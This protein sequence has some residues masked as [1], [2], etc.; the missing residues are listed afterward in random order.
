M[1][2][3]EITFII[4]ALIIL[5]VIGNILF[6]KLAERRNPPIG[7][8]IV[9]IRRRPLRAHAARAEIADSGVQFQGSSSSNR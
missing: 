3:G 7:R 4:V 1:T 8:F 6:S 5:L 2:A 9:S